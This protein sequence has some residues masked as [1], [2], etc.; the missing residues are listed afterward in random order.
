MKAIMELKMTG[1]IVIAC[2]LFGLVPLVVSGIVMWSTSRQGVER[3]AQ[4][5]HAA[6]N[7]IADKIDRNLF[8]RYGD[9]QAFG[10]N[11]IVHQRQ[12]WYQSGE[13]NPIVTAMDRYV[14]TYGIYYLTILVDTEGKVIAVN[15]RDDQGREIDTDD[16]YGRDYSQQPWFRDAIAGHFY[17]S[18]KDSISGT[19]VEH[20]YVDDDVVRTYQNEGYSL[21]FTAPVTDAEGNIIAVWKNVA[22]F[23]LVEEIIWSTY[24]ELKTRGLDS[25]EITL[26]DQDGHVLVDCD[27]T[28]HGTEEILHDPAVIGKL[29]LAKL[30]VEAAV[31][32]GRGTIWSD[33]QQFS[34]SQTADASGRLRTAARCSWLR[35]NAVGAS[36][37]G[38]MPMRH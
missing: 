16:I 3:I 11:N 12:H 17:A 14:A 2:L 38:P 15:S 24:R 18:G 21:G 30:N 35:W 6:A 13:S 33:L 9:V 27:P 28:L 25:T 10:L 22:K 8:E 20:F 34:L 32:A 19:V 31:Q 36:W 29:N 4:Q 26:L 37:Y 5:Y 7:N 1:K 23:R